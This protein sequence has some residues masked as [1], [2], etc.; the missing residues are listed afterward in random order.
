MSSMAKTLPGHSYW[1]GHMP[2]KSWTNQKPSKEPLTIDHPIRNQCVQGS[3][4]LQLSQGSWELDK[5]W[6][7]LLLDG[8]TD[9]LIP[10]PPPTPPPP[11]RTPHT[12]PEAAAIPTRSPSPEPVSGHADRSLRIALL[13]SVPSPERRTSRFPLPSEAPSGC[14]ARSAQSRPPALPSPTPPSYPP[15]RPRGPQEVEEKTAPSA[16]AGQRRGGPREKFEARR[17]AG[18]ARSPGG[19]G[20]SA[21]TRCIDTPTRRQ[22]LATSAAHDTHGHT[23]PG[24]PRRGHRQAPQPRPQR[25]AAAGR[26]HARVGT[27]TPG[28]GRAGRAAFVPGPSPRRARS[29][30]PG[31][32]R[33]RGAPPPRRARTHLEGGAAPRR[34]ARPP[35][36]ARPLGAPTPRPAAGGSGSVAKVPR[37][38]ARRPTSRR[39][40]GPTLGSV[41]KVR[42]SRPLRAARLPASC[43]QIP[44]PA[45]R[46]PSRR[47]RW[48]RGREHLEVAKMFWGTFL[49]AGPLPNLAWGTRTFTLGVLGPWDCDPI[50]AQA[51][52]GKAAQL[53]VD[54]VNQEPSLLPGL[55]LASVVLSTGCDTSHSLA[56]F[57]THKNT[58][59]AFVGPVNPGYCPAAA[60]LAQGWGKTLFSWTCEVPESQSE[61]VP[62]LPSPGH[63][64]LSVMRHFGWAHLAIVSSHQDIWVATAQQLAATLKTHGLHVGL[65][66]SLG[67]GEQGATKVL[68]QLCH[69]DGLKIVVL[70][71]HSALLGGSEQTALLRHAGAKGLADGRL[72]FLPYDTLLFALPYHNRSYPT[73]GDSGSLQEVYDAVLTI[74]LESGPEYEAFTVAGAGGEAT[75]HL[76]AEKV[77]P[78]FGTIYDAVVMLAYALNH[79]ESHGAGLS[80]AHLGDHTGTLDVAG[81][82]QR[83]RTD[84]KGRRLARYII[85]DTDGRGSQLVPTHILHTE[86]WHMQPL[87]KAIHFPGG[88]SPAHDSSCWFDPSTLCMKGAQPLG[89]LLA[90][91]LACVLALA[92]GAV[93]VLIRLGVQQLQLAQDPHSVLLTP[94]EFTFLHRSPSQWRLHMERASQSRNVVDTES[95]RSA[96]EEST[97]SLPDPQEAINMALYQGDWVW[98][99]KFEAGT[100]PELRPSCLSLLRKMREMQHKNLAVCHGF[101]TAPGVSALVLEHC[102]RGSL[103]DLLR[104]EALRLDWT[105]KASLLLDLIHGMRYLHHRHFPHGRLKSRNCVVNSHFVL[106]VTDH[107]YAELLDAQQSLQPQPA[108]EELLWTAP[109]LLRKPGGPGRGTFKGDVFSM[110]II[111]QEVLTRGPPYCSSGLSA[112]EIT[113]KVTSPPPLCRPLVS[114]EH[115]PHDCI[116][117][118]K[119]CWEEDPHDRPSLDQIYRQFKSIN[120]GKRPSAV[121]SMLRMLEKYSQSLEDLVQ[122]RTKELELERQKADKLLSH[123]LPPSVAGALKMG[124]TVEPEYFDQVTIYFSDIVGFTTI[125]ALSEPMEVVCLLNDLYTLYDAVLGSHDVYKVETIGDAYMVASG[126]PR[127]NGRRHA[128]EIANMALDIL[129]SVGD[130]RMRHAPDAPV[131]IRIGLHSGPCVAGVVGLTMPR[132]CLFGDTVNTASRME[133][134]GLPYRI[135]ISGSTVEALLSLNEGYKIDLRGQTELKGKGMEETYWLVGKA[136]FPRPLPAAL[137]IKP[138]EPWQDL[139]NQEIK[140][141]FAKARQSAAGPRTLGEAPALP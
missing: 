68:K 132:Y 37:R 8:R 88:A 10:T 47:S 129:S 102:N 84:E 45:P 89:S 11:P 43:I 106:K 4:S 75:G 124:A 65:V 5:L 108:P 125:S 86:T 98:L 38:G 92:G 139:I 69:V 130:F 7:S 80:G 71:M 120:S 39:S 58:V 15:W 34:H 77:S 9:P 79:S 12:H 83:I 101:L 13:S 24:H 27:K 76:E 127:R 55:Q 95:L 104:N 119:Q 114:P 29:V 128:A 138:G 107:G 70:C 53:A 121:D 26:T 72:V 50:F 93:M 67:P 16:L 115:G 90:L 63:V 18:G 28:S 112:E 91:V 133:S 103:E 21:R 36:A 61:L 46:R 82:S 117:L 3:L 126:M 66:T 33:G 118:M 123:M 97:R 52:P 6:L 41:S 44:A 73:L 122:E 22:E 140:A 57:L 94:Q 19:V 48:P 109:E 32:L 20:L 96:A 135:H 51:L 141:A 131:H 54:R 49:W 56:T 17:R 111:L 2:M 31:K 1:W 60:L 105:F 74:S 40:P 78:L 99:K 100:A 64:L 136:G 137:H 85:F 116:Q 14:P 62:T 35:G 25:A 42:S 81:F 30:R 59:A 87:G 110:G 23:R 134:T 113:R